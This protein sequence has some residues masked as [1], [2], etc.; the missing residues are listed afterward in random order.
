LSFQIV[1]GA[2][3]GS[4]L[5]RFLHLILYGLRLCGAIPLL[6]GA[7]WSGWR[8]SSSLVPRTRGERRR[9]KEFSGDRR[10]N[11]VRI[12]LSGNIAS[13]SRPPAEPDGSVTL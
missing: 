10:K 5:V 12:K 13:S 6:V 9:T 11:A 7:L 4:A 1:S 8:K 3:G 2:I